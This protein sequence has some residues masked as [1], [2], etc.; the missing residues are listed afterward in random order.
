MNRYLEHYEQSALFTWAASQSIIHPE[1]EWMYAIPNSAR[2]SPRQ[3]AWMKAEG[4]RSGVWDI[5]LPVPRAPYHGMYIEMKT[6]GNVLT[7][8][9]GAFRAALEKHY[10]FYV[11]TG[12]WAQAQ[13][14]ILRYLLIEDNP[15][16]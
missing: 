2:R 11:C 14:A 13:E 4:L 6:K 12:S 16:F 1:L 3:G 8:A 15:R 5:H 10:L 7:P 9:Q